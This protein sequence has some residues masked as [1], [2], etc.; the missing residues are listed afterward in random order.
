M[1]SLI[2]LAGGKVVKV[3]SQ[4]SFVIIN[5]KNDD[6]YSTYINE[7]NNIYSQELVLTSILR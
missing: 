2:E 5:E 4:N 1:A 6:A 3:Y 7:H